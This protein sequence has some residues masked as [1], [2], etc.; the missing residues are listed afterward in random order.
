MSIVNVIVNQTQA[1]LPSTLQGTGA[2][3]SQGGTTTASGTLSHLTQLSDL[4]ALLPTPLALTSL[5]WTT[6]LVTATATAAHGFT[7]GTALSLT[8]LGAVPA[9][10]NGT[11]MCTPTTTTAFTY[12]LASNPGTATTPGSYQPG[13][14]TELVAMNTTFWAMGSTASVNVLELGVGTPTAGVATLTTY[15]ANNPLTIYDI[16]VPRA[17]DGVAAFLT[18]LTQY[19][20]LTAMIYFWITTT[21]ATFSSYVP[22]MKCAVC[23]IEAPGL[24]VTEFDAAGA[25]WT[26]LNYRPSST[27]KVPPYA[28]TEVP[29]LTPYPLPGNGSKFSAWKAAGVNW[30]GTGYEGGI[31]T[32]IIFYGTT[33]DGRPLNYWYSID[34]SQINV[35]L[36]VANEVINGSN[37]VINPLYLDQDGINR[38]QARAAKTISSGITFGLVLG[39]VVQS[40]LDGPSFALALN[41]GNFAGQAVINCVPFVPYFT[42][43]PSDYRIGQY[44]GMSIT[45]TPLRGFQQITFVINATDFVV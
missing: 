41:S 40:E 3:I 9:G 44:N 35:K 16:V 27:Q 15:L 5:T 2:F 17:W 12:A 11:F 42:A 30:I 6:G 4:T 26:P 43:S 14:V 1:P 22:A 19:E 32:A 10:Y 38:I 25:V 29:G 23:F 39:T 21:N 7:I 13:S 8:V 37:S 20:A 34:W 28:F 36:N 33:M 45:M 31:T 18:L 24:P